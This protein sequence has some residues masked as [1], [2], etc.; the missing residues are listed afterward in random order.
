MEDIKDLMKEGAKLGYLWTEN[1]FEFGDPLTNKGA[2]RKIN[3]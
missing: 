3:Q 2:P 1:F